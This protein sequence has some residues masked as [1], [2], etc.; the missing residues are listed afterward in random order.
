M[1]RAQLLPAVTPDVLDDGATIACR[2]VKAA[3]TGG[4][5]RLFSRVCV[6]KTCS[7]MQDATKMAARDAVS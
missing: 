2:W 6:P 4:A 5:R 3:K 1:L 7:I